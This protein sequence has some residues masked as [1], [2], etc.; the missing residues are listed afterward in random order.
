MD[1]QQGIIQANCQIIE[2]IYESANSLVYRGIIRPDKRPIILKILKENYPTPSELNRY[3]QEYEITRSLNYDGVI[4]AYDLQRYENSLVIFLEDFGGESLKLLMGSRQFTLQE[5]LSIAIKI[6]ESLA[7]IHAANIIHKDINPSNIVYNPQT[8]QLKIIDFGISTR[9]SGKNQAIYNIEQLEGTLAYIAPEQT[10]R[11]NR[12]IDYRSDFYSLGVTFYEL[13]TN[14]LPFAIADPIELVHSHIAQQPVPPHEQVKT[15]NLTSAKIPLPVSDIVMKLLRKTPE[16]RYQSAWGIKADLENCL[17]SLQCFGQIDRFSLAIQDICDHFHIP[18]KL[19][20]REKEITQLLMA[21]KQVS[22]SSAELILVSGYS[23]IGKSALVN[24]IHKP[25]LRKRCYFIRGKFDQLKRDIPY[26][27]ITLAFQDLIQQLLSESEAALQTWKQQLLE[28][29]EPNARVIMDVIPELEKIIGKQ[30][31]VEELGAT[32]A[33]NR[34]NLFFQRFIRVFTKQEH[35]LVIFLDDLQWA[36]LASLKLIEL[37]ITDIDSQYLLIIGAYRDNEVDATHPLRQAL[38]Q[39]EKE[40]G[41]LCNISLQP[42]E[43][44]YINQLIADTLNCSIEDAKILAELINNKTQGNPFFLTQLLQYLYKEKL[45]LF[46]YNRNNWYWNVEKI[47]RVG[48]SDNVVDLTISKIT[49]LDKNTQNILQLAGCLGNQFNLEILS[50]VN[51]KSQMTTARELQPALESGLILPL[52]N[53]YKIPL[54]WKQEEISIGTLEISD[55][56]IPKIPEYITYKFLHDR[57]QQAAYALLPEADKK[58]IHLQIGRFLVKRI[59]ANKLEEKI[60]EIVNHLNEGYELIVEQSEKNDL[61]KLNLQ[62]G[63]KAK[64][65]TA[66]QIALKYLEVALSLLSAN[67]WEQ[68]YELTLK[69]YVETL[70][71]LYLNTKYA[72]IED[73]AENILKETDCII[74]KIKTYQIKISYYY[75]IFQN[76]KAIDTALKILPE[77]GIDISDRYIDVNEQIEQKQKYI[78]SLFKYQKIEDIANLPTIK[79]TQQLSAIQIL[80]HILSATHTTNFSLFIWV[81][82][83]LVDFC[84]QHGNSPQASSIY[85]TYGMLLCATKIDINYGY[86]FGKLSL[87]LFEKLNAV[88]SEV[89]VLQ[90]YYGQVWHWKE[91][92]RNIVVQEKLINGFSKGINTGEYEFASYTAINYCLIK[93]LGGESLEEV[94]RNYQKYTNLIQKIKQ[95]FTFYS[96]KIFYNLTKILSRS[97]YSIPII[98]GNSQ[99]KEDEY[100]QEWTEQN[101]EWLLLF[102]YFSKTLYFYL[103]KDYDSA[104]VN[105]TKAEK[106]KNGTSAYLTAPQHNLYCSLSF[107]AHYHNCTVKQQTLILEQV[108]KNQAD[109]KLWASHCPENFQNKSDLVEAE[110]ARVLGQ[111]WQAQEFYEQAIQGAKKS[112]FI[113]EEALAY[114]RAAEFYLALGREEIGKL[115]LRNAHHCYSIWGAKSKVKQLESEYP[116]YLLGVTNQSKFKILSPIIS[117]NGT[118][119][120]ILDLSTVI[121]ASQAIS[122]EI[123]LEKLLQNL[124]KIVIENAGAQK[125]FLIINHEGNW[126]IEAQGTVDNDQIT[127]LQSIPIESVDLGKSIPILPNT[128]INYVIRAQ[129]YIVLNEAVREGQ[130]IN[131]PYVVATQSKSIL[132]TPLLNQGQLR[133]IVYLENNLTT[134]AFTSE[135]VELLNILSAQAA[136]SI[137]NSRLYQTLEQRVEER[138]KELSQ[139]LEVL[140]AT[141]AELLFEN[142][143]L[144]S[145]EQP[146]TFNYQVGG[147]L[148]MDSPTYVVRSADRNLYKALK[149]GEFCYILNARQMGKSS[150]MVR[151]MQHLNQEEFRCAAIDMTRIGSENVTPE[152]WYKGFAVE[153]WRSFSLLKKVNLKAWWNEKKDISPV[154][155]LSQFIEEVI[156]VE[157]GQKDDYLLQNIVIFIDEIDSILGLNF[158][159]NDF[160]ALIR[161]CYNQR[162]LNPEYRRLIFAFF[163][164]ATPADLISDRQMTPFNI[165][166]AIQLEGFKE[167]EAQPLL[168]GLTEKIS[169]PQVLLKEILAWTGGQPFLTQK[170]CQLI[171]SSSVPIPTNQEAEWT[172]NLVQQKIIDNWES[173]DEPEHLKTI[174]DRILES[175]QQPARLLE[176]Y[177]QIL[178]GEE[179]V[180]VD[181]PEER[182][183][184]LS[185][186]VVKQQGILK[187]RNRIYAKIFD[188]SWVEAILG[189]TLS[190]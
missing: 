86:E 88:K 52:S 123:K 15:L 101:N 54:L 115:Y 169:N 132:C 11:M 161:S 18:E 105:S 73:F 21:F 14:Q 174:R 44:Q 65:S 41:R 28:A 25:M 67:S 47:D 156:L 111:H 158:P 122:G 110:K 148:S 76:Q 171:C 55:A 107:L 125:A 154:Q 20:G 32:E 8:E 64:A 133:G 58:V 71:L 33:Q 151:M 57:V 22:Q 134:G 50:A 29:L 40:A 95:K 179:I 113:H 78:K 181:S 136:I 186:L 155:R 130:F 9:L 2:K 142:D 98:I 91:H 146:S 164:V 106:Y 183:L 90:V 153:L 140:K 159:V 141:Q 120:E 80:Q 12:G 180:A 96:I 60:F 24:E 75:A 173:Q 176:L 121:K 162:S 66:Y 92:I 68:Q 61:A 87:N 63:Q 118:D 187:V 103:L 70:E 13:L 152:Q 189:S 172:E 144:R 138:T 128:I 51:N 116:Q 72:Q 53:D 165:G 7:A 45:L 145:T 26:G 19:Y 170:L 100:L 143:L 5:F 167:H 1:C 102:A 89:F 175:E 35:P 36:D 16:E 62:A 185:G 160:F 182:E 163:G 48:I 39:I 124:M 178:S 10:G 81:I 184:L 149:Q 129:E 37:L 3:K 108:E 114:E 17:N 38:E 188:C 77:L 157:V 177:G 168:N 27:A 56:F 150:L 82:L 83:T 59:K 190:H 85:V 6:T 137:D 139:T 79:N 147:S 104:F 30:Q 69:I 131:D 166:R 23:G 34:F 94:N 84:I 4:K 119:G 97:N 49:K 46:D 31:P 127:I 112:E 74:D 93:F 43:F 117:T 109:M 135:R 126:T 99:E 42:L